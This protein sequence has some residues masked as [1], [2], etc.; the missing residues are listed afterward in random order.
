[1]A[2]RHIARTTGSALNVRL[3][4]GDISTQNVDVIVTTSSPQ[5]FVKGSGSAITKALMR[6]AGSQLQSAMVQAG[7]TQ[8]HQ[9]GDVVHTSGYQLQ[10]QE[11]YHV[12]VANY[13]PNIHSNSKHNLVQAIKTCLQNADQAGYTSIAFPTLAT[14]GF[15][16]PAQRVARWMKHELDSFKPKNLKRVVIVML[17]TDSGAVV[18]QNEFNSQTQQNQSS[19]SQ[20]T[21]TIGSINVIVKQG[22]ITIENSDAIIC[23]TAHNYDLSGQ[24]GQAIVQRG[25]HPI[26]TE[27]Q[28]QIVTLKNYRVTRAGQLPCGYVFHVVT[29]ND[30]T[31]LENVLLEVFE[32]ADSLGITSMSIPAIGTGNNSLT[33]SAAA[34]HINRA[35]HIFERNG[36]TSP[37]LHQINIVVF[38]QQMMGDFQ[39]EF[40][41][42][43]SQAHV[44]S[45][46]NLGKLPTFSSAVQDTDNV[47]LYICSNQQNN[48]DKALKSINQHIQSITTVKYI[49]DEI[50]KQLTSIEVEEIE[51]LARKHQ[52]KIETNE[53]AFVTRM[54][55][56]GMK[57]S[58]LETY[59]K[60]VEIISEL[61]RAVSCAESVRWKYRGNAREGEFPLRVNLKL[62]ESYKVPML[63][64]YI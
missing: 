27:L 57:D 46:S 23:P 44:A 37:T 8:S 40:S 60:V 50:V 3:V 17:P 47:T 41:V 64:I 36:R 6:I 1:M 12:M 7:Q 52:V 58:V 62:E 48:I 20:S 25:G 19:S 4:Q 16:Y 35:I 31:Q 45:K 43:A 49:D 2:G 53:T 33:S 21:K 54:I 24:V 18:F 5:N 32:E 29:G 55:I 14:G 26:Q 39:Q 63:Y 56:R 11:V 22:D 28:Q 59:S 34:R 38:Q 15:G 13:Q 30:G 9:V 61:K 10:C 42:S 51:Q